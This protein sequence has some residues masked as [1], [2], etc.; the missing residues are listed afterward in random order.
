MGDGEESADGFGRILRLAPDCDPTALKLTAEEGFLLSRIDGHTPWRL[1]RA[2]GCM[3]PDEADLCMEGWL[4]SGVLEVSGVEQ[5]PT[6]PRTP[7]K[8]AV[9]PMGAAQSATAISSRPGEIDEAL[10]DESLDIDLE[11]QR[12]ILTFE[13]G[14]CQSYYVVLGIEADADAKQIKRAYFELSKEFHPDRYF[15]KNVAG[16]SARLDRIFKRVLEAYEI[17]SDPKLRAEVAEAAAQ[18][19]P[20]S[21]DGGGEP[22]VPNP[23]AYK[24]K[25]KLDRL[26]QRMPFRIPGRIMEERRRKA[27]QFFAA[28]EQSSHG[29][30]MIEAASS[31]RIAISF[32]PENAMYRNALGDFKAKAAEQQARKLLDQSAEIGAMSKDQL[33]QALGY[34]DDVLFYKPHDPD[35]NDRAAGV[36]LMM[37]DS[38][39]ALEY[40]MSAVE[41]SPDVGRYH[42]TLG[43]V[44]L[45]KREMGHARNEFQKA[46]KLDEGDVDARRTLASLR[47]GTVTE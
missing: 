46:L 27:R 3:D 11:V 10:L 45:A 22:F 31:V 35:L 29:G 12:R 4:A 13:S 5:R 7:P 20:G 17:L 24:T 37:D 39:K 14:L 25:T 33:V 34:L 1:L 40:A 41:H 43:K 18:A 32:D 9:E 21:S 26:R 2:I 44:H 16:Y 47:L 15:K 38:K 36:A 23:D 30:K 42:T 28:A 19:S 8:R 6:R